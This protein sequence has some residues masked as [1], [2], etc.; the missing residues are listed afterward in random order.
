MRETPPG[1]TDAFYQRLM[2]HGTYVGPGHW[3]EMPD[4]YF[5]LGYGWSSESELELGLKGISQALD[6]SPNLLPGTSPMTAES[7]EPRRPIG[8][9]ITLT[10]EKR[11]EGW[12]S[13]VTA[14]AGQLRNNV[15]Q[16]R[17]VDIS[18]LAPNSGVRLYA[19]LENEQET[20]S[21][22]LRGATN[23][24]MSLS[25]AERQ[26]GVVTA[27]NGNHGLGVALAAQKTGTPAEVFVS[28]WVAPERAARIEDLGAMVTRTD[29]QPL[30]AE[31]AARA[32]A[33]QT[34][35][36]Y[37]SPYN[38]PDVMAGQGTVA[39]E[40]LEQV[41]SVNAVFVTVG[42]GG[43][44]GGIGAFLK[45]LSPATEVVGCWPR[46]SRVLYESLQAGHIVEYPEQKTFSDSSTGGVE[47]GS[48][49]FDAAQAV[50]DTTVLVD[51]G[52]ILRAMRL[53]RQRY[54]WLI[55]GAAAVA[56]AAFLKT[57][58]DYAG[59]TIVVLFCGGNVSEWV[60]KEL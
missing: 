27:S 17:V 10:K 12:A 26:R 29:G 36:T 13:R 5:R 46:N 25:Q 34:G 2:E 59:K 33:A 47:E 11:I 56:L 42:G 31:K 49:T 18:D 43:L 19:K 20:G 38:D 60:R 23:K 8:S 57:S 45:H 6:G 58:D 50:I 54:G 40:L 9:E 14:A 22:K 44:I 7:S 55:E 3:F 24:I 1:G 41:P 48:I 51:E 30:D 37:I 39:V 4:A 35:R 16:T 15:S 53:V 21:F 52:E 32:S 28:Q